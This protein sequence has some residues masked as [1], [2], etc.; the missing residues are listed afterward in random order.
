M[1]TEQEIDLAQ[2]LLWKK[3]KITKLITEFKSCKKTLAV[4]EPVHNHSDLKYEGEDTRL[5]KNTQNE[6]M[7]KINL[8][9]LD[10]L[11]DAL[12]IIEKEI[13]LLVKT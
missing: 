1:L 10:A 8:V 11:T 3:K 4:C 5:L 9:A 13:S 7:Q 6:I 2:S 12:E